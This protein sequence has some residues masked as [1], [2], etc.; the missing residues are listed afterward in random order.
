MA[1]LQPNDLLLICSDGLTDMVPDWKIREILRDHA[2]RPGTAVTKLI[3][4]TNYHGG[5]DNISV[6]LAQACATDFLPLAV[7]RSAAVLKARIGWL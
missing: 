2:N 5:R 4:T 3:E 7:A 1:E 6:I